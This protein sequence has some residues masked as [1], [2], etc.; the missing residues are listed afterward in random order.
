MTKHQSSGSNSHK[1]QWPRPHR[2]LES[3]CRKLSSARY[4][5]EQKRKKKNGSKITS[6]SAFSEASEFIQ[7][8]VCAEILH[9]PF[10]KVVWFL[11][12]ETLNG[13][14]MDISTHRPK[15]A[16]ESGADLCFSLKDSETVHFSTIPGKRWL[17][18]ALVAA[19]SRWSYTA[20]W[21]RWLLSCSR[22]HRQSQ[23][24]SWKCLLLL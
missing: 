8:L 2:R 7:S 17:I 12:S 14:L 16:R 3:V 20:Q 6:V 1:A 19:L 22:N 9:Q 13:C 21:H 24:K 11:W 23:V 5:D 18:I 15:S 10:T 4:K